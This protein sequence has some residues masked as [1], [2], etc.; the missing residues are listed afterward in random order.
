MT[1]KLSEIVVAN[2]SFIRVHRSFAV[3]V[4]N[5]EMMDRSLQMLMMNNGDQIPVARRMLAEVGAI[6]RSFNAGEG[7]VI[8]VQ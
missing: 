2:P 3:N 8:G 4:P 6:I 7:G 1:A 5:I